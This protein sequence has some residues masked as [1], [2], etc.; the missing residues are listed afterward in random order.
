M[1]TSAASQA[2]ELAFQVITPLVTILGAWLAH[3]LV[4][5][6][7]D[8]TGIDIPDKQ[9]SKIDEWVEAGINLAAEKSYKKVKEKTE[10][11]TG[12]E[13]LEEAADFVFALVAARGW[14][15]WTKDKLKSKIES[16]IGVHR[17]NGGVPTLEDK[18]K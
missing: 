14:D 3:R 18:A 11:L 16:A 17:A 8:K 5:L 4:K 2:T 6:F 1:D 9:E 13:K 12:P 15:D 10:K 7:E